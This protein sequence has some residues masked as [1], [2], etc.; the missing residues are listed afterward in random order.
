M[1]DQF[2]WINALFALTGGLLL[3]IIPTLAMRV[4]GLPGTNQ[5]FYPRLFGAALLGIGLAIIIEGAG[6]KSV[7]LGAGGLVAIN[8]IASVVLGLQLILGTTGMTLRGRVL[9]W[10]IAFS[11][12]LLGFAF[13]AFT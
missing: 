9:L 8:I 11:L 1:L 3:L 7:G 13:I 12:G 6:T 2:L 5:L 4:L 10:F